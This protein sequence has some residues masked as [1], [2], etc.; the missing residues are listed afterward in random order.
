LAQDIP[1]RFS[2]DEA[3]IAGDQAIVMVDFYWGGNPTPSKRRVD[4][5]LVDGEW[6][7][8]DVSLVEP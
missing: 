1:E 2:V 8:T 4:L 5:T 7:I 3:E 6:Q